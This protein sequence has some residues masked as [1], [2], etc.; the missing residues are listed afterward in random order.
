MTALDPRPSVGDVEP[1]P[2]PAYETHVVENQPPALENYNP[3]ETDAAL[4][5]A[6]IREGGEWGLERLNR[7]GAIVGSARVIGLGFQANRFPPILRTHDRF[8]RRI[9][10]V[11]FHPAWHELMTIGIE[12]ETH[13]LPWRFARDPGARASARPSSF[14]FISK[15]PASAA[16]SR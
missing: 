9:D 13:A 4:K 1:E 12:H 10:E 14:C 8:G 7:F 11:E 6:V 5:Q 2:A 15:R 3:F 16:R